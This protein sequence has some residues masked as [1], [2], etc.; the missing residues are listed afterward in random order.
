MKAFDF[1]AIEQPTWDVTLGQ[2][3]DRIVVRLLYPTLDLIDKFT[4]MTPELGTAAKTKDVNS[5][6]AIFDVVASVLSCNDQNI[7]F[8]A[9]ELRDKYRLTFLGVTKFSAGYM[10]FLR[11]AQTAKN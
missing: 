5:V 8:T 7:T 11:E 3:D 1:N 10:E 2:G 6:R 9:E 4:A